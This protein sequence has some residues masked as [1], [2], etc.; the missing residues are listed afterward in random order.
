MGWKGLGGNSIMPQQYLNDFGEEITSSYLDDYGNEIT[1]IKPNRRHRRYQNG[2]STTLR[3]SS[4]KPKEKIKVPSFLEG[5]L[6]DPNISGSQKLSDVFTGRKKDTAGREIV[7]GI[8]KSVLPEWKSQPETYWGGFGK[9]IYND[10]LRPMASP[11]GMI[12]SAMPGKMPLKKPLGLPSA[13]LYGGPSGGSGQISIGDDL[14]GDSARR[15]E[16][17]GNPPKITYK[18]QNAQPPII[19]VE[20]IK[21]M[22]EV[23]LGRSADLLDSP[24]RFETDSGFAASPGSIESLP[25]SQPRPPG[26]WDMNTSPDR[27]I[28]QGVRPGSLPERRAGDERLLRPSDKSIP[29]NRQT[30]LLNKLG[31]KEGVN[32]PQALD[33]IKGL[34][35]NSIVPGASI[36]DVSEQ[37]RP[38]LGTLDEMPQSI[39][40]PGLGTM[41]NNADRSTLSEPGALDRMNAMSDEE[42]RAAT[43]RPKAPISEEPFNPDTLFPPKPTPEEIEASKIAARDMKWDLREKKRAGKKMNPPEMGRGGRFSDESGIA[44]ISGEGEGIGSKLA[45]SRFAQELKRSY[46]EAGGGPWA[47]AD[48]VGNTIKSA[49]STGD[50][51]GPLR[52]GAALIH[53]KEFRES[54]PEMLKMFNDEKVYK[55]AMDDISNHPLFKN[56]VDN[57]LELTGLSVGKEER[58]LNTAMEEIPGYG[59][60]VRASD[61]AYTGFLNKLRFDTYNS[62]LNDAVA[63][64]YKPGKDKALAKDIA[65]FVNEATGRGGLG[66]VGEKG[67]SL[68]NSAFYSPRLGMGRLRMINR[69]INPYMYYKQSAFVRKEALKSAISLA[70][71]NMTVNGLA[72]AAGGKVTY[73]ITNSDF[74]KNKFGNTRVDLGAGFLQPLVL[75]GR[76]IT[77]KNTSSTSGRTSE[78]GT[79]YGQTSEGDLIKR[80]LT[81]KEAP[82]IGLATDLWTG[83]DFQGQDKNRA[84]AVVERFVP[85]I[86]SDLKEIIEDDPKMIPLII[87]GILGASVQT[88]KRPPKRMQLSMPKMS[89]NP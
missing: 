58:F 28:S 87:P 32:Q 77:G 7:S 13:K 54:L 83:K 14:L 55:A 2:E 18:N 20:P 76:I 41:I 25:E 80:F 53:K 36:D 84:G 64:G 61:R 10:I 29:D 57:G 5:G 82:L 42:F 3:E 88:Y 50:L 15:A 62:L 74:M 59:R 39:D 56:A 52:Q 46:D 85:M 26:P 73:D 8:D 31:G 49:M 38:G 21:S 47:A 67:A 75:A 86:L 81:S 43:S 12:G 35:D 4:T 17:I 37:I 68:L 79:G 16:V 34:P 23:P 19:D 72:V 24:P 71:F 6:L 63:A 60:V 70:S 30:E 44:S 27:R 48:V 89:L 40:Q 78:L 22:P 45:N 66:K 11:E 69:V 1:S 33:A 51:S 9:S 65:Q